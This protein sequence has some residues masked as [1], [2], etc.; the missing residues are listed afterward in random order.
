MLSFPKKDLGK[1][2]VH[3][4]SPELPLCECGRITALVRRAE[5]MVNVWRVE[6]GCGLTTS[7]CL[8]QINATVKWCRATWDKE[9]DK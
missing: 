1:V 8:S 6:C 7:A 2:L 5:G 3:R 9:S 4:P